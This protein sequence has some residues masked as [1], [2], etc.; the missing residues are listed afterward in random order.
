MIY[1]K[2]VEV[3]VSSLFETKWMVDLINV[4]MKRVSEYPDSG[5]LYFDIL[6]KC[7]ITD[8]RHTESEL[9]DMFGL[10]RSRFFER[11]R[12]A[13]MLLGIAL[14]GFAIPEI[15]NSFLATSGNLEEA[16]NVMDTASS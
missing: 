4:A 9:L 13:T 7:Y 12:E 16:T 6:S 1:R 15:K 8:T 10:E 2:T 11:K 14:W 3:K 5:K